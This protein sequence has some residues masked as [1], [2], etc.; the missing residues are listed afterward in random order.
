MYGRYVSRVPYRMFAFDNPG[1]KEG[2]SLRSVKEFYAEG[3]SVF[4]GPHKYSQARLLYY[5]PELFEL[6]ES[7]AQNEGLP[8]P[9]RTK[10]QEFITEQ[11]LPKKEKKEE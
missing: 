4:H 11:K 1:T 5:A 6:L 7:E 10:L 2:H 3:Y 8:I 9:N